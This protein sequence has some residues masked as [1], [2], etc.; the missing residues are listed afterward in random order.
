MLPIL[1]DSAACHC[2]NDSCILILESWSSMG[3]DQMWYPL[4]EDLTCREA[5]SHLV[6]AVEQ[7]AKEG[8]SAQPCALL[9]SSAR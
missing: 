8:R 6:K 4:H 7:V 9:K 1:N 2:F 5:V 3:I